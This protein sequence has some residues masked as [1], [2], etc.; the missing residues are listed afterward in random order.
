[1]ILFFSVSKRNI[2]SLVVWKNKIKNYFIFL[3]KKQEKVS[4]IFFKKKMKTLSLFCLL[5]FFASF[6]SA[7]EMPESFMFLSNQNYSRIG[8][9]IT[10][11]T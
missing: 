8:T 2:F 10:N 5:F 6:I 3:K 1:M 7:M 11:D 9:E 4:S